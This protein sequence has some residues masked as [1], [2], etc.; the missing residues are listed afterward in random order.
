MGFDGVGLDIYRLRRL[1][2]DLVKN[3]WGRS[4]MF[5]GIFCNFIE[6]GKGNKCAEETH[7]IGMGKS[8]TRVVKRRN[9]DDNCFDR[10][11]D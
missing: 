1:S 6:E 10:R 7:G 5:S 4:G 9:I 8:L 2:L 11:K 3:E